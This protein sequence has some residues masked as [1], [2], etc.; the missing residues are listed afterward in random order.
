MSAD[1]WAI[2]PRCKIQSDAE[3]ATKRM[4]VE[5]S[6]GKIPADEYIA[7]LESVR[8]QSEL[9]TSFREDYELGVSEIGEFYVIYSGSCTDCGLEHKFR[10][11]Q[12]LDISPA[13]ASAKARKARKG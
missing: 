8:E 2:C 12:K 11:E 10:H 7:S 6:Y 1:N 13:Q 4:A 9:E 3:F 5:S